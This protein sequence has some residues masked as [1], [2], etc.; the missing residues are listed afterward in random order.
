MDV[1]AGYDPKDELTVF[2]V[3]PHARATLRELREVRP[4]DGLQDRR[5]ARVHGQGAV[6]RHGRGDHRH[7]RSRGRATCASSAPPSSIPARAARCSPAASAKYNPQV[8]NKLFTR[9]FPKL[10]PVGTKGEPQ[11]DHLA[12]LLDMSFD[13][14]QVPAELTIRDF[15]EP[16]PWVKAVT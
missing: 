6:H 15:G 2:S 4:L 5:H 16:R 13:P 14:A 1:I 11:G 12:K 9:Q 8:H 7:R 10:F 3:G